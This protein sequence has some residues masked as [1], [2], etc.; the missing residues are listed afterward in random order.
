MYL[1]N[2]K[3]FLY[4]F[5]L[6]FAKLIRNKIKIFMFALLLVDIVSKSP[7]NHLRCPATIKHLKI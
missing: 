2:T 1:T 3:V 7:V 5:V 6:T 4:Q